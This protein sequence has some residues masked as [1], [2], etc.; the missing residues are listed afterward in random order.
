[1]PAKSSRSWLRTCVHHEIVNRRRGAVEAPPLGDLVGDQRRDAVVVGVLQRRRHDEAGEESARLTSTML[2]GVVC[3]PSALRR[4]DS[5]TMMRVNEVTVMRIAGARLSTVSSTSSWT[6]RPVEEPPSP[7]RSSVS[8]CASAGAARERQQQ[9]RRAPRAAQPCGLHRARR[10]RSS[11]GETAAPTMPLSMTRSSCE[12]EQHE[13]LGAV[14]LQQHEPALAVERQHLEDGEA[15]RLPPA[16]ARRP[17]RPRRRATQAQAKMSGM[18]KA[19]AS[20]KR[21]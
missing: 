15:R 1:M 2:G 10:R 9:R 14:A 5:T 20:T 17:P 18:T 13:M 19:S 4:N 16:A 7:P 6:M 3:V 8:V 11:A 21:Q 12:A